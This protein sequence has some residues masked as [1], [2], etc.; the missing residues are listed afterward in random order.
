MK[1]NNSTSRR[2]PD[3]S[4]AKYTRLDKKLMGYMWQ[5]ECRGCVGYG[6]TKKFALQDLQSAPAYQR[7]VK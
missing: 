2:L 1:I 4:T 3:N 7:N 6:D 5:V